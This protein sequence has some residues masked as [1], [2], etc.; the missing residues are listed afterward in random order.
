[1]ITQ[2]FRIPEM[3]SRHDLRA[4]S[5]CV[6]DVPGVRTVEANLDTRTLSVTGTADA[7]AVQT[8]IRRAGYQAI[9]LSNRP[10]PDS[11]AGSNAGTKEQR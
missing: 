7:T 2:S 8:A 11:T 5:A 1:V 3:N 9:I 4:I 10:E 6:S